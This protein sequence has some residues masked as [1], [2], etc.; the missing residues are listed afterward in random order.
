MPISQKRKLKFGAVV[1]SNVKTISKQQSF[2]LNPSLTDPRVRVHCRFTAYDHGYSYTRKVDQ[3]QNQGTWGIGK[4]C[5]SPGP[6]LDHTWQRGA[7]RKHYFFAE[8]A[9]GCKGE[10]Q[11][12]IKMFAPNYTWYSVYGP[13]I[14][15]I[16]ISGELVRHAKSQVLPRPSQNLH[17][18]RSPG[19]PR[20]LKNWRDIV[21]AASLRAQAGE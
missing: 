18:G 6:G 7:D 12:G 17:S 14:G 16:S 4:M 9:Y 20:A 1:T 13:Q 10:N 5:G 15:S 21:L 3:G 11:V 8:P 19:N 2:N